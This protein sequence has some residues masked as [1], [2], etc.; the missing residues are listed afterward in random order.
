[1]TDPG[2]EAPRWGVGSSKMRTLN[3]SLA[4]LRLARAVQSAC[5]QMITARLLSVSLLALVACR[6]A[7]GKQSER[8]RAAPAAI[9]AAPAAAKVEPQVNAA[10]D[11]TA[12][13]KKQDLAKGDQQ[14]S[15]WTP[16]EFKQGMSR[17]K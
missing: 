3:K 4:R 9:P 2:P 8:A 10:M 13:T 6:E 17:W 11:G 7:N 1:M 16:A 5:H 15:E 12:P 14:D